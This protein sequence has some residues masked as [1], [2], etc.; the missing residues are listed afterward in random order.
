MA[1]MRPP[2]APLPWIRRSRTPLQASGPARRQPLENASTS[3]P[4]PLTLA[5][6]HRAR[7]TSELASF[8]VYGRGACVAASL[9]AGLSLLPLLLALGPGPVVKRELERL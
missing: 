9:V 3:S 6:T 2:G 1:P 5:A 8:T 7:P 4:S